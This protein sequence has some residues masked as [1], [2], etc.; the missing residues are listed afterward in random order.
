MRA[1]AY[2]IDQIIRVIF[3]YCD[4]VLFPTSGPTKGERLA[5]VTREILSASDLEPSAVDGIGVCVGPGSYTGLRVGLSFARGLALVDDLPAV[6]IGS[7]ELVA[8]A[9]CESGAAGKILAV[10]DAGRE[11]VYAAAFETG[12]WLGLLFLIP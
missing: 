8:L 7:L 9:G 1:R 12:A 6:G 2:L 5:E 4:R 11:R 10:L 3:D